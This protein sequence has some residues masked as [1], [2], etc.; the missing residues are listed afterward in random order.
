M[1]KQLRERHR[2][3]G[4]VHQSVP[5]TWPDTCGEPNGPLL[6][7]FMWEGRENDGVWVDQ[8]AALDHIHRIALGS[9]RGVQPS[10]PAYCNT[11]LEGITTPKQ[12]YRDNLDGPLDRLSALR[13]SYDSDNVYPVS[14][15][16]R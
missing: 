6:V 16:R 11:T 2:E 14:S 10:A 5:S 12:I 3:D 9:R 1:V 4:R 7:Y 15:D 8:M 13:N